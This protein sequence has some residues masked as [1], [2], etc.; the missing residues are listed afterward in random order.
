MFGSVQDATPSHDGE[1]FAIHLDGA[2]CAAAD[3]QR[4]SIARA[5][6]YRSTFQAAICC[7]TINIKNRQVSQRC[8][9]TECNNVIYS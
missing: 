8:S 5:I 6:S 4:L 1:N 3:P 7:Y 2:V 9:L